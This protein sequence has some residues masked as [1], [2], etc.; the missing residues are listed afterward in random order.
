MKIA[1]LGTRGVPARY[2]GFETFYEEL[3]VRLA[4]R[5]HEVTVYNRSHFIRDV[6]GSY[7]GM[8]LVSLPCIH[9]KHLE[10]ISHTLLSTLHAA[11]QK[12]DIMY[13]SIVGNAPV[14]RLA[15]KKALLNVDGADAEREKWG[16]FAR[17]Y[18]RR[19]EK[20]ATRSKAVLIADALAIQRRYRETYDA[21]TIFAPY[22][23]NVRQN[24]GTA[25]LK[26]WGLE[27]ERYILYVGRF[28]PEN[29]IHDLI[30]T[31]VELDTDM[32]LVVV[33]DAPY[34][35][36]YKKRLQDLANDRV[37]FTGYAFG[38]EY[39]QLS[40][41][42]YLYVQPSRIEGTRP[43]ILDQLGFGNCVLVR[44][45]QVNL[46]TIADAGISFDEQ[47]DRS[48]YKSLTHLLRNPEEVSD[49]R[50]RAAAR[51]ST[52]YNWDW[53]TDFY[54]WLFGAMIRGEDLKSYDAFLKQRQEETS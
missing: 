35:E 39:E 38:E 25:A 20:T 36:A 24:K 17:W 45:S 32:K 31:F 3:G 1:L 15:G 21:N 9:T 11:S 7:R 2:S 14:A 37:V 54:E 18:Q 50:A 27:S 28:V 5:G 51:I 34:S 19:C 30:T 40:S 33:G 6:K 53:V 8:R 12:Y 22:G 52:F 26:K 48:L 46:D 43:A 44:G 42:A 49:Y 23:G 13:Y 4:R 47:D 41:H 16:P 10:T 29:R